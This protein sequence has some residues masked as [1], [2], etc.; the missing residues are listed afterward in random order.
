MWPEDM[1]E[2]AA[3]GDDCGEEA[4]GRLDRAPQAMTGNLAV[5]LSAMGHEGKTFRSD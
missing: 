3:V 1:N 4:G 5:I 2:G